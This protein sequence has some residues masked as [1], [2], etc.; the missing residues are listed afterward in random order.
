[1]FDHGFRDSEHP[2]GFHMNDIKPAPLEDRILYTA[3][4]APGGVDGRGDDQGGAV[5][6]TTF[7]IR[8]VTAKVK[9][10]PRLVIEK[11]IVNQDDV[12][13][14]LA[15]LTEIERFLIRNCD[16]AAKKAPVYRSRS[17]PPLPPVVGFDGTP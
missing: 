16:G 4:T 10:D 5:V 7:D 11:K 14:A 8:E 1:M 13:A 6:L 2:R 15:K 12:D 9:D 17:L 3:V